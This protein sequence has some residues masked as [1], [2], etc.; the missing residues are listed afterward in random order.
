MD[1]RLAYEGYTGLGEW[2][3]SPSFSSGSGT[4]RFGKVTTEWGGHLAKP[5]CAA[6]L[7]GYQDIFVTSRR[8]TPAKVDPIALFVARLLVGGCMFVY[9]TYVRCIRVG[10]KAKGKA[11]DTVVREQEKIDVVVQQHVRLARHRCNSWNARGINGPNKDRGM[12]M[13]L[14]SSYHHDQRN[15]RCDTRAPILIVVNLTGQHLLPCK[16]RS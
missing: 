11:D 2:R 16:S 7:S 13:I 12:R 9:L 6:S 5:P 8:I 10:T 1:C 14:I 15:V 4:W 3:G